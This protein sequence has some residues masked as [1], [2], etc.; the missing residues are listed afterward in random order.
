MKKRLT[1]GLITAVVL[2]GAAYVFKAPLR[3]FVS[4]FPAF[5]QLLGKKTVE[6]QLETYG[7]AARTRLRAK[8]NEKGFL[9]PPAKL[10]MLAFK[11]TRMLEVYVGS[12]DGLF[13]H[14]HTYPILGASGKLG[15]KLRE[16]DF[17]CLK[18]VSIGV[19]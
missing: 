17:Q 14:L 6:E 10:T 15:P 1:I 2:T 5:R 4:Q 19:S 13:Q 11:D 12:A 3:D 9:Y 18:G 7:A 8:F 16:G